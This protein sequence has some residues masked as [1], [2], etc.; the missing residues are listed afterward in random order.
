LPAEAL[1]RVS[2]LDQDPQLQVNALERAGCWPIYEEKKSGVSKGRPVRDEVLRELRPGDTLTVWKLDRLGRNATEVVGIIR[3]LELRGIGFR[4][5]T[6]S[7][8]TTSASGRLQVTILAGFAEFERDMIK[9]RTM[10]GKLRRAEEGKHPGGR[11]RF[12]FEQDQ[13]TVREDE[14]ALIREAATRLLAGETA[15]SVVESWNDR[16]VPAYGGGR[17]QVS[18]LRTILCNPRTAPILGKDLHEQVIW[19]FRQSGR[20]WQGR[21]AEHL[22]SGILRCQC[23]QP[24]YVV[25]SS[26][27]PTNQQTVYRCQK[28]KG[29]GGRSQGCGKVHVSERAA[30]RWAAEAF[31]AAVAAPE[32]AAALNQR[33]SELLAGEL[34]AEQLDEW[35]AEIAE[36]ERILPTRFGTEDHRRRHDD[37]QR[38]VRDATER[39]LQRPELQALLDLPKS[40]AKLRA[41]WSSWS[42]TERRAWLKR[43]LEHITV[44]PA[45]STGLGSNV[46]ARFDPV[47]KI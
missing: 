26:K 21:P 34:T 5:L 39:L 37:L 12:G 15:S 10:A 29:S 41:A 33:R 18:P 2:T 7:I 16:G 38:M 44:K 23:G 8:D 17:W 20:Q 13:E 45:T 6:Q 30:D 36:L 19:L 24:M 28:A 11:R 9:E 31:V 14:A 42:I 27:S 22:L 40:V 1:A 35:R 47:W 25:V 3:D 46:A 43:V 32:F 4:C